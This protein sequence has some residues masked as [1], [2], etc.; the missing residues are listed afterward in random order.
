MNAHP[1]A[2]G[3]KLLSARRK[4]WVSV[5]FIDEPRSRGPRRELWRAGVEEGGDTG[6]SHGE[7]FK[8][9]TPQSLPAKSHPHN[10]RSTL[11]PAQ[12]NGSADVWCD[13]NVLSRACS[14]MNHSSQ[15]A[16]IPGK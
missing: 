10:T 9:A 1:S 4:A 16:R 13:G 2:A 14:W 15:R 7:A 3:A 12:W 6:L 5:N 11:R 8:N